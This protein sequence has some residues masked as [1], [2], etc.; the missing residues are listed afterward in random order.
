MLTLYDFEMSGNCYKARLLLQLL[1]VPHRLHAIDFYPG[2][3]HKGPALLRLNPLGELPVLEDD[4]LVLYDSGAI[5]VYLAS[6]YDQGGSWYPRMAADALARVTLWLLFAD[7]LSRAVSA[8]RAHD[9]MFYDGD[10]EACRASAH[11]RFRILDRQLWFSERT[12]P[13]WLCGGEHPT[14]ADIACFP[15]VMLS[16]EAGIAR[17][18]YP[19]LRRWTDRLRELPRFIPMVGIFQHL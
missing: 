11:Q 8:A 15:Y 4:G 1:D 10:V 16:E 6:R 19:A 5:L 12:S 18:D 17:R 14:I 7:A 3:E 13:G 9:G 2:R